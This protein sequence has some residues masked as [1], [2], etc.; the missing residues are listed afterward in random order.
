MRF[1]FFAEG[2]E[3]GGGFI[4][5]RGKRGPSTIVGPSY[6]GKGSTSRSCLTAKVRGEQRSSSTTITEKGRVRLTTIENISI[7]ISFEG[8]GERRESPILMSSHSD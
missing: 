3:R 6:R 2:R 4:L 5:S 8:R 1:K 7:L